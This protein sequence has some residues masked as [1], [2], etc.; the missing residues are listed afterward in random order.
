MEARRY[1]GTEARIHFDTETQWRG[2]RG[3][4]V[5]EAWRCRFEETEHHS[6]AEVRRRGGAEEQGRGGA[7]VR[8]LVIAL[9]SGINCI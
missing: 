2:V 3:S 9:L 8:R 4:G 1:T 7:E 6:G 5:S